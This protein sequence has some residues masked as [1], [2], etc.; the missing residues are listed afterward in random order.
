MEADNGCSCGCFSRMAMASS[1]AAEMR[2][3]LYDNLG[4][5]SSAGISHSKVLAKLVGKIHKP[6]QQTTILPTFAGEFLSSK[7]VREIPGM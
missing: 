4:L 5:T 1:L 3:S 2:K 7:N 6:N